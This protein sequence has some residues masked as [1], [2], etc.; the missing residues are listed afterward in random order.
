MGVPANAPDKRPCSR[1]QVLV[2]VLSALS[3]LRRDNQSTKANIRELLNAVMPLKQLSP[4]EATQL[5]MKHLVNRSRSTSCRLKAQ[6][7]TCHQSRDP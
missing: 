1:I 2:A 7:R 5:V 4:E 3:S 6:R